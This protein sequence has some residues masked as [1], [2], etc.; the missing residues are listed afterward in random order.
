MKGI[1]LISF[2]ILGLILIAPA[3]DSSSDDDEGEAGSGG[4]EAGSGGS[5][6]TGGSGGLPYY[7]G[8]GG[9]SGAGGAGTGGEAG[10][11]AG[12][13]GGATGGTGGGPGGTIREGQRCSL[14]AECQ[15]GLT[16]VNFGQDVDGSSVDIC[17]RVCADTP[18][19]NEKEECLIVNPENPRSDKV[20]F[21]MEEEE[22]GRCGLGQTTDCAAPMQ[23]ILFD[24]DQLLG[25][26]FTICC[27]DTCS[28]TDAEAVGAVD[29]QANQVCLS[30]II[31][32]TQYPFVG[33]CGTAA[34]RGESCD[35]I[36]GIGCTE[37]NECAPVD[38]EDIQN[39][40]PPVDL[41]C[42]QQ[43]SEDDQTCDEGT[44]TK[45]TQDTNSYWLCY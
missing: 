25:L 10:T 22:F 19:C 15:S 36:S 30:G 12:G 21:L 23:C 5:S 14:N 39:P 4:G 18:D 33:V 41:A 16:C 29:C 13:T 38:Q 42:R 40:T 43:C 20:C 2:L 7:A 34:E 8:S 24:E 11:P 44:C 9:E 35:I 45:F 27:T 28:P 37:G 26:C 3:C 31:S 1:K 32:S 6:V 17:A